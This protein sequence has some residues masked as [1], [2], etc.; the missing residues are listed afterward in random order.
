MENVLTF[1]RLAWRFLVNRVTP[2]CCFP[3]ASY[4]LFAQP[5]LLNPD[6]VR[7]STIWSARN[8]QALQEPI[9]LGTLLT[10]FTR[11][12]LVLDAAVQPLLILL[13]ST[14]KPG[15]SSNEQDDV[16]YHGTSQIPSVSS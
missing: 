15:K 16:F 5:R 14:Y 8:I 13:S 11:S 7:Y 4:R 9:F 2:S 3:A 10:G 12:R 1:M 6:R